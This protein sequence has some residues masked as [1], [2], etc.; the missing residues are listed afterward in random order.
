[1]WEAICSW[2]AGVFSAARPQKADWEALVSALQGEVTRLVARV[3]ENEERAAARLEAQEKK[4]AGLGRA[5]GKCAADH[6]RKDAEIVALRELCERQ[7]GQIDAQ[8]A[9]IDA[10]K[11]ALVQAKSAPAIPT[12]H[13]PPP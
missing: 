13:A 10:L 8:Q 12:R 5:L 7:Q 2:V 1:M 9:E 11:A 3:R 6:A 4:I